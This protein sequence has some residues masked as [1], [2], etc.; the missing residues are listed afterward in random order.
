SGLSVRKSRLIYIEQARELTI[1]ATLDQ[2]VY[3]PGDTARLRFA[4]TDG[5]GKPRP[6]A[7]SLAAVDE[8]VYA[9]LQQRPGL[10]QAFF[11]AEQELLQPVYTIYPAW[12]PDRS[13]PVDEEPRR[14]LELAVFSLAAYTAENEINIEKG[15][16]E[17]R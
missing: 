6:G 9:V 10:E 8:A 7:I 3:R 17:G 1:S 2:E 12:S 5:E 4:L 13:L 16:R 14:E 15:F 11:L